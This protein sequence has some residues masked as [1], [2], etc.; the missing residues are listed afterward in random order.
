[1]N[2]GLLPRLD[3]AES[4]VLA[5]GSSQPARWLHDAIISPPEPETPTTRTGEPP[6]LAERKARRMSR[7]QAEKMAADAADYDGRI[8]GGR[9]QEGP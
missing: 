5:A 9:L 6:S 3:I 8:K 1:M 7:E 4:A 2:Q